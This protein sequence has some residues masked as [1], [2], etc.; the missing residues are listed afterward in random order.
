[1]QNTVDTIRRGLQA[2]PNQKYA[3][4]GYSQGATVVLEALG[5]LDHETTKS[6]NAGVLVGNPYRTPGRTSNVDS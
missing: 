6:I 5:K 3:L 4:L 1:M 2:C